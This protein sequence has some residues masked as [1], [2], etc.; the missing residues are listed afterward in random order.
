MNNQSDTLIE[1]DLEEKNFGNILIIIGCSYF[2]LI[3]SASL[4]FLW[5]FNKPILELFNDTEFQLLFCIH[6]IYPIVSLCL[7]I[8]RKRLGWSLS[9]F[10][11]ILN[12][13]YGIVV[14][15]EVLK[16]D[17][18]LLFILLQSI[19]LVLLYQKSLVEKFNISRKWIKT[20]TYIS[21][22]TAIIF[23]LSVVIA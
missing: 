6:I 9:V 13:S 10:Y 11:S 1:F 17:I 8:I 12:V 15:F 19:L 23:L 14:Y 2:L 18:T 22:I 16:L 3:A 7:F 5:L 21:L 4:Y 20:T